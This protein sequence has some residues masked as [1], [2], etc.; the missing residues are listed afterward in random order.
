[1][2][3]ALSMLALALGVGIIFQ[4]LASGADV[5]KGKAAFQQ[6]CASC[7]GS[8]GKGDSPAAAALNPK[9]RDLS[10]K[11]YAAS[12]K[13]PYLLQIIKGGGAAVKKSPLMPAIGNTLKEDQIQD[14]IAYLRSLAK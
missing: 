12:L 5:A 11:T 7:H 13:D 3:T 14:V 9:P 10:D 4:G 6:Y 2:K 8:A 1:M